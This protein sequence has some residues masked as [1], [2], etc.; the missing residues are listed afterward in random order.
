M[1]IKVR[2]CFDINISNHDINKLIKIGV[3]EK[4]KDALNNPE[5]Y[6]QEFCES[7]SKGLSF[8]SQ[9][10]IIGYINCG[11][12]WMKSMILHEID[13]VK[14]TNILYKFRVNRFKKPNNLYNGIR[15]H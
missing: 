9:N 14:V 7:V 5:C 4:F 11:F 6:D 13:W 12:S 1:K 15:F 10:D 8:F 3:L 2:Q